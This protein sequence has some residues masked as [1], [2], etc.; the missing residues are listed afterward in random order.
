MTRKDAM[1][2][3]RQHGRFYNESTKW[4]P[5]F[6]LPGVEGFKV[7]GTNQYSGEVA[8]FVS[9]PLSRWDG[10][11]PWC[12]ELLTHTK[13]LF[14]DVSIYPIREVENFIPLEYGHDGL[15]DHVKVV[16]SIDPISAKASP[17]SRGQLAYALNVLGC[18][19]PVSFG[20]V[21]RKGWRLGFEC[22]PKDYAV[23][24][25]APDFTRQRVNDLVAE[26]E[27]GEKSLAQWFMTEQRMEEIDQA[28]TARWALERKRKAETK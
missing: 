24:R 23:L 22:M 20:C 25:L 27:K 26:G 11:T 7:I 9:F 6:T 2:A 18:D 10:N 28:R 4:L 1:E 21:D 5:I 17:V 12:S 16:R 15:H 19:P 3:M 14:A 8:V 13:A